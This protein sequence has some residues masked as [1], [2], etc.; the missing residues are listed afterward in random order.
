MKD[1]LLD[2]LVRLLHIPGIGTFIKK[3]GRLLF[4]AWVERIDERIKFYDVRS[5]A[6]RKSGATVF[7]RANHQGKSAQ[8]GAQAFRGA[9][10]T[11]IRAWL[12]SS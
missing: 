8:E 10:T 7:R 3:A 12:S 6:R 4:P 9:S 1:R 5:R 11:T 2:A